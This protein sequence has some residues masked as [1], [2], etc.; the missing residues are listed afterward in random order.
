MGWRLA[1]RPLQTR[2]SRLDPARNGPRGLPGASTR[3]FARP[4]V[5][6]GEHRAH[7]GV[8]SEEA[9]EPA[10]GR[11][12]GDQV[13]RP[14]G[15][16]DA[17]GEVAQARLGLGQ[18]G[19]HLLSRER[20]GAG[21]GEVVAALEVDEQR[22]AR[23]LHEEALV[24]KDRVLE[25]DREDAVE[26]PGQLVGAVAPAGD[27]GLRERGEAREVGGEDGAADG[28]APWPEGAAVDRGEH[29]VERHVG[30]ESREHRAAVADGLFGEVCRQRSFR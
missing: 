6:G 8:A 23:K 20:G 22:V 24:G 5:V 2:S 1:T 27:V 7:R 14:A 10:G 12:Y 28:P 15:D 29:R 26:Q 13:E 17:D 4:D 16:A 30:D 18:L 21:A 25:Q 3:M 19:H 11:A 9:V